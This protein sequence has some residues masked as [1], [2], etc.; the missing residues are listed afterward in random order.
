LDHVLISTISYLFPRTQDYNDYGNRSSQ[1]RHL[2]FNFNSNEIHQRRYEQYSNHNNLD[3]PFR[4]HQE[5]A[6]EPLQRHYPTNKTYNFDGVYDNSNHHNINNAQLSQAEQ[7]FHDAHDTH[8]A[9]ET[10]SAV[11]QNTHNSDGL[12]VDGAGDDEDEDDLQEGRSDTEDDDSQYGYDDDNALIGSDEDQASHPAS[13]H[14]ELSFPHPTQNDLDYIEN[15]PAFHSGGN[16]D[17]AGGYDMGMFSKQA[18]H[19]GVQI[20]IG[21]LFRC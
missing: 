21:P 14:S 4:Q 19:D 5:P 6:N 2:N 18:S 3:E 10:H 15:D 16:F 12:S 20:L 1:H 7:N 13:Q 8:V 9:P 17:Y 11:I